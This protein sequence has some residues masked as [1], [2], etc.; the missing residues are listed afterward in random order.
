[1]GQHRHE[2]AQAGADHRHLDLDKHEFVGEQVVYLAPEGE[3]TNAR[4]GRAARPRFLGASEPL[5]G[6]ADRLRELATWITDHPLFA[7]SQVNRT[8][9]HL[10][11]RGL[12]D[13]ID[14]FRPTNPASH[15]ELL[16]QLAQDF[17]ARK[18]DLRWLIRTIMQ[19]R[20]YQLSSEPHDGNGGDEL[21]YSHA[22]PRRLL[23]EQLLDAQHQAMGV[24]ARFNG[25]PAGMRAGQLPG[26]EAVRLR[27]KKRTSADTFL[28]LFG[29][30]MRLLSCE[31][32]RSSETTMGQA[33]NLVSG[34]EMASLLTASNR[35]DALI[36]A[37]RT[38][39]QI[40]EELYWAALSRAPLQAELIE[41]MAHVEKAENRR[42][43]FEDVSWALLNA[44]EFVFRY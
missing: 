30:P 25:Y 12:V 17:A 4:N 37:G 22:I 31:C 36:A 16:E 32:E 14:D 11:G 13:P 40:L 7:R 18:F 3:V 1:V 6:D 20:S 8:W 44:K 38:D 26:V 27:E 19:S 43:A 2:K 35:V 39:R 21:N 9:Y 42:S 24:P 28:T 15:P 23:A 10:M 33:F 34:P 29:K 5:A 41:T